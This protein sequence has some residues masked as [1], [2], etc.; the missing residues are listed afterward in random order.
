MIRYLLLEQAE[1]YRD[2]GVAGLDNIYGG[3]GITLHPWHINTVWVDPRL[4]NWNALPSMPY[5]YLSDAQF[6][7]VSGG[8][9]LMFGQNYPEA[10]TLYKELRYETIGGVST[11]GQ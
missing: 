10:L 3:G 2:W 7:A 4:F 6:V 5:Y 11:I 9:I 1:I 8:R